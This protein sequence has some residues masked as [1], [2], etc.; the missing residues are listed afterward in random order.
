MHAAE[1]IPKE[2][3]PAEGKRAIG[4]ACVLFTSGGLDANRAVQ[5]AF[6][7]ATSGGTTDTVAPDSGD[8]GPGVRPPPRLPPR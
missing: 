5:R 4:R 7:E 6:E 8:D 1:S 2:Q 3:W